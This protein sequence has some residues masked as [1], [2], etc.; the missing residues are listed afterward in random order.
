M[1]KKFYP[2]AYVESVFVIDYQ[3]LYEK[4]YRGLIFDID[5]TLVHHGDDSTKA[6]DALFRLIQDIGF[7]TV[8]LTNNDE[9]RVL[10]FLKNIDSM[11]ICEA[12]KPDTA[13]YLKAVEMMN[14]DKNRVLFIGDQLF[15]DILGSNRSGIASILVQFIRQPGEIKIGKRRQLERILLKF[16]KRNK[17]L[18][19]RLGN[20]CKKEV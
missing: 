10:R 16:Y 8:L 2:Y 17:A 18:S 6:V 14:I 12:G 20:I 9:P 5:N 13:N 11:Y 4:G 7:K 3:K 1:F 15:T 19:N